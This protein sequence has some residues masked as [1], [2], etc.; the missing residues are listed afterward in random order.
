[1]PACRI[2]FSLEATTGLFSIRYCCYCSLSCGFKFLGVSK[3]SSW[4][5]VILDSGKCLCWLSLTW[6]MNSWLAKSA[7]GNGRDALIYRLWF[8]QSEST[9]VWFFLILVIYFSST[10]ILFSKSSIS[11]LLTEAVEVTVMNPFMLALLYW[12][13]LSSAAMSNGWYTSWIG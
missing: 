5:P 7:V 8:E 12:S 9:L 10:E 3:S 1:M 4:W 13:S 11:P 6:D 2:E